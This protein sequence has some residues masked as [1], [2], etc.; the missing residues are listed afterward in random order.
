M[1]YI[2]T[3]LI[4]TVLTVG[5]F[6]SGDFRGVVRA[7]AATLDI[8]KSGTGSGTITSSP[9]GI[10]C[11]ATCTASFPSGSTATLTATPSSGSSSMAWTGFSGCFGIGT[12]T[13]TMTSGPSVQASF[14]ANPASTPK[15]VYYSVGQNTN[16]H[17]TG[18]PTMSISS[19]VATFS[20]AQTATNMG[21]GD[22]VTYN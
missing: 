4:L 13:I 5:Y 19:G 10:N 14:T 2:K 7:E 12:C 20:V 8:Y 11:G 18:S 6:F 9:A 16:D 21:V 15:S 1:K 3:L 22:R 17:K